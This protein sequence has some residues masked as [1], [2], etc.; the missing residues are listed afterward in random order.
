[1]RAQPLVRGRAQNVS[2]ID[3]KAWYMMEIATTHRMDRAAFV[4]AFG[5]IVE[6]SPWVAER[7]FTAQPLASVAALHGAM[8]AAVRSAS[9][10]EQLALLRAHPDLAGREAQAG[11]TSCA[12]SQRLAYASRYMRCGATTRA[13]RSA[14]GP[15]VRMARSPIR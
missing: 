12:A 4:A 3:P 11:T 10:E 15:S 2:D 13:Y 6:H 14:R 8:V 9:R 5:G 1:M 7:A